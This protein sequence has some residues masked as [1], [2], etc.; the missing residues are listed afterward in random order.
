MVQYYTS[1][2]LSLNDGKG[3]GPFMFA[4]TEMEMAGKFFG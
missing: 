3:V 1:V 4:A 2:P